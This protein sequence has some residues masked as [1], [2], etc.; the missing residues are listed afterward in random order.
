MARL[1]W[2]GWLVTKWDSLP[3]RRQSPIPVLTGLDVE[4]LRWSRPTHYPYTKPPPDSNGPVIFHWGEYGSTGKNRDRRTRA[5][6]DNKPVPVHQLGGLEERC[7]LP[8]R[9]GTTSP[10]LPVRGLEERC[11]LPRWGGTTSPSPPVRGSA[12]ALWAP[13]AGWDN[14]P[15]STS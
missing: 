5:G 8:R 7:E 9:G 6:W 1:S 2:R 14:K 11:E 12:G 15:L 10:S 3:T 13:P 4:Q